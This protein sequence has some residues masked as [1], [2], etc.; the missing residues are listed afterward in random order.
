M[1]NKKFKS[2]LTCFFCRYEITKHNK[3]SKHVLYNKKMKPICR[4]CTKNKHK[5]LDINYKNTDTQ[6]KLCNKPTLYKKC[7]ECSICNHFFHGKCL[8][9]SRHDIEKIENICNFFT[10][11]LCNLDMFPNQTEP[12]KQRL[13]VKTIPKAK[14]NLKNCLTCFNKIPK[15]IYP[16]KYLLYKDEKRCLCEKCSIIGIEIPVRD[17]SSIEFQDCSIC[18]K[19]V[20]YESI[21]CNLC[22]HLVHPYCNGI[23]KDELRKYGMVDDN[24]YCKNCNINIYPNYLITKTKE[25]T[26]TKK[27][28]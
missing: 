4:H 11:K 14:L 5:A 18:Q 3:S 25:M 6:C 9:L 7:I 17:K 28:K 12:D 8:D 15:F 13:K 20:R 22:Q 26:V 16:N 1:K 10:C 27:N 23:G 2:K 24:W 19:L 21:Y